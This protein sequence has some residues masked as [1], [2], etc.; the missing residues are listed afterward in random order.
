MMY[1]SSALSYSNEEDVGAYGVRAAVGRRGHS[2][3]L[4]EGSSSR[5]SHIVLALLLH[6]N[7]GPS[8][9]SV[10]RLFNRDIRLCNTL[11]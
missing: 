11:C 5:I 6:R 10:R 2:G 3:D 1:A 8:L 7:L 4:T 9:V